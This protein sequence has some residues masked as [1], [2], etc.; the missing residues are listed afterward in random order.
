MGGGEWGKGM[1]DDEM[2]GDTS[3]LLLVDGRRNVI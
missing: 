2:G 1:G 3:L